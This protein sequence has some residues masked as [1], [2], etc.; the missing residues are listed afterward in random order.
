LLGLIFCMWYVSEKTLSVHSIVTTR[1]E[2]FYWLTILCTSALGTATGDLYSEGLGLGYLLTGII[3]ALLISVFAIAWKLRLH[4][5]LAFWLIYILTRPLGASL[6]DLLSQPRNHGGFGLGA[7]MTSILFCGGILLI[8]TYLSITKRDV[9]NKPTE[10][11][12]A[13]LAEKGGM[14]QTVIVV[15]LLVVAGVSGYYVRKAQLTMVTVPQATSSTGA[16]IQLSPLGDLSTFST[17]TQ[18]TLDLLNANKQSEA[19]TRIGDLE[20]AWD[21]GQARLKPMNRAAWTKVDDKIDTVL[22]ELRA[23]TPDIVTE[24]I[25]LQA[26][27]SVLKNT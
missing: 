27:L 17:I 5:V 12:N 24:K 8:V 1:R 25:A 13:D 3:V 16:I 20:Y 19:T 22:R 6:G 26:L 10:E 14:L 11:L 23:V 15:F 4:S 9:I 21:Q 2:A 18:D 7:T